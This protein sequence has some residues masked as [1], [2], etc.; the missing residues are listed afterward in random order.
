[1]SDST[2]VKILWVR[3]Y[4]DGPINGLADYQGE[5]VWFC[6]SM[7]PSSRSYSL[8]KLDPD[9]LK[10]I[11]ED[12][13]SFCEKTGAPLNHGDPI[14]IFR[15]NHIP[16]ITLYNH[17]YNPQDVF[18]TYITSIKEENFSNYLVPYQLSLQ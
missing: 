2:Y 11:E 5:K 15:N 7:V 10:L 1:M 16:N 13:I 18:G 4:H 17:T 9:F 6:R 14:K 8:V 3:D 12:H